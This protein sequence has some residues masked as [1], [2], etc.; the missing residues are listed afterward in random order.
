MALA[1][2]GSYYLVPYREVEKDAEEISVS[3][4]NFKLRMIEEDG[5]LKFKGKLYEPLDL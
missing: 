2:D 5:K 1:F 4:G 3:D